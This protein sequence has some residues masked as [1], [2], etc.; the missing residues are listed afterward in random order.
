MHR[1][2]LFLQANNRKEVCKIIF[3]DL[4][5]AYDI[6]PIIKL[7]ET[8]EKSNISHTLIKALKELKRILN[9]ELK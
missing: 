8:L 3:V 1:S 9:L 5:N 6:I 2:C 4:Q 7:W